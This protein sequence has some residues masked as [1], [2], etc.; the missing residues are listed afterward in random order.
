[1]TI[2]TNM[3][4]RGTDILLGGNPEFLARME[5]DP[6][7]EADSH[8]AALVRSRTLCEGEKKLVIEAGGLHILGTERHESRRIDN[9][10]RG[11]A[12][13]QGDPGS[14]R[15]FLSL[16]DDLLR[17]FG[18]DRVA[19]IMEFVGIEEGQPIEHGMV[20]KSI[21]GAQ[22]KVEGHHFD[23]RKHLLDYDDVMNQQ[24]KTV[25]ELRRHVL[26][27]REIRDRV[28]DLVDEYTG[29]MVDIFCPA[30]EKAPDWNA[31]FED[32]VETFGFSSASPTPRATA[33]AGREGLLRR[34]EAVRRARVRAR[35][36]GDAQARA[37]HLPA[38]D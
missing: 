17:I 25:Y 18:S 9:Q 8:A 24:R 37:V 12:G 16:E 6:L 31:G 10:L 38:G 20:S 29:L 32:R 11:R 1:M 14:S 15:F 33:R 28:L 5:A 13:R 3:A 34:R 23:M 36:R 4:G 19:K 22:K 30:D 27:G 35:P 7:T 2:A 26:G 21:E